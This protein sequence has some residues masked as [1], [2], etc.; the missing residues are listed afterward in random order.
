MDVSAIKK[1]F[2]GMVAF[3]LFSCGGEEKKPD[4]ILPESKM[5]SVMIDLRIAEGKVAVLTLNND[6]SRVLFKELEKRVF[7]DHEIDSASYVKS[8]QYYMLRPEEAL[9]IA[10]AVID[11]L[12]VI[13]Q[14][15]ETGKR[16]D[17]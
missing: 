11:S 2:L 16:P 6:S 5:I 3:L 4:D 15:Q 1:V 7:N 13:Q 12:K 10:D 14:I 9:Y 17:R 8:Y